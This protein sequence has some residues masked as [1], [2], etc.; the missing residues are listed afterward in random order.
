[1]SMFASSSLP[2]ALSWSQLPSWIRAL[3]WIDLG[4]LGVVVAFAV[5]VF[6]IR[7]L[8]P[9]IGAIAWVTA[10]E[11][12]QQPLFIILILLG[13]AALFIFLFLP[14]NTMGEDIV[15]VVT[16][17]LTVVKLL[18][19]FLAIWTASTTIAD[20]IEGKT[21]LMVLAK[22]VG[23]RSFIIGKF[24]GVMI[25]VSVM[26]LILGIFFTNTVSF[27]IV[28]DAREASKDVPDAIECFN[29]IVDIL[30]GLVLAYLETMIMAAVTVAISTRL[31]LLP[32]LTI[33][34]TV[35]ILGHLIPE[36]VQSS[37]NQLPMVT[38]I[39]DCASA[40]LPVLYH[41]SMESPIAMKMYLPWSYVFWA[42]IYAL[43][44][45]LMALLL[46]LLLFE[47]RDLA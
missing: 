13:L 8:M 40:F 21:A 5:I 37:A 46:S 39:G 2:F 28:Y 30:P 45:C 20:E 27:K 25:A 41:F 9:K 14:Y 6:L 7:L 24:L 36:I 31:S 44:Y 43:L 18:A 12:V 33:S 35:Y 23:R 11:S 17:G 4:A 29:Y 32:N 15:L 16:Q 22:P 19:I 34:F 26:F 1:M 42:G 10:K 47:D 3:Q 38:F